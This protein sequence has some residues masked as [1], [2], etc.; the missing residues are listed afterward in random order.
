MPRYNKYK[1]KDSGQREQYNSGMVRDTQQGKPGFHFLLTDQPYEDQ[2][3]TRWAALMSRGAEKYGNR[4]WQKAESKEELER[5]KASA[6]RHFIQ[7][8]CGENDE[9]HAAAVLF[10]INAAEYVKH[11]REVLDSENP[12][13]H[14]S[15]YDDEGLDYKLNTVGGGEFSISREEYNQDLDDVCE[16]LG[17]DVIEPEYYDAMEQMVADMVDREINYRFGIENEDDDRDVFGAEYED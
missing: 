5:F 12:T 16:E 13:G 15:S 4:N 14:S 1:T 17:I 8:F 2:L 9:D 10:N 11:K 3:L 6:F 7:W